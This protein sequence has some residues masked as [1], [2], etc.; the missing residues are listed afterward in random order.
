MRARWEAAWPKPP[1]AGRIGKILPAKYHRPAL[2][3]AV[4]VLAL[5]GAIVQLRWHKA[6][7]APPAP[8][9]QSAPEAAV[10]A[11]Q[12]AARRARATRARAR[13]S[14]AASA[15][16][17]GR[18]ASPRWPRTRR[19]RRF[20]RRKAPKALPCEWERSSKG[21][22]PKASQKASETI[23]GKIQMR[24]RVTVDSEGKVSNA[25][26]DSPGPSKYFANLAL[27]A[28]QHSRFKPA[29]A[30][31]QAVAS[32]WVLQFE[33]TRSGVEATPVRVSP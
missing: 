33:F 22:L 4:F 26:L 1:K 6:E 27:E 12:G 11:P 19:H 24:V 15:A 8:E 25:E 13:R 32:A 14:H 17:R 30:S 31:G 3:A 16:R 21:F 20:A 18:E 5:T 2:V 7:P 9:E 28:A 10:P 29:Q 23:S